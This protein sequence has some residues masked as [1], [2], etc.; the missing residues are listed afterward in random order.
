MQRRGI[1]WCTL[2]CKCFVVATFKVVQ[3]IPILL[4]RKKLQ[5]CLVAHVQRAIQDSKA[6]L[7][8][9]K[10]LMF[11]KLVIEGNGKHNFTR[12]NKENK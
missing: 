10:T 2:M 9:V 5:C 11:I 3:S 6:A 1:K 8:L 7:S 12:L 4:H